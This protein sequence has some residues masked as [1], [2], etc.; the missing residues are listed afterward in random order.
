VSFAGAFDLKVADGSLR[1]NGRKT[2]SYLADIRGNALDIV[3]HGKLPMLLVSKV[4]LME[5]HL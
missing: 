4:E 5:G 2:R 1:V 3:S